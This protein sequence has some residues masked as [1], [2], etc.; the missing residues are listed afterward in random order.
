MLRCSDDPMTLVY[1]QSYPIYHDLISADGWIALENRDKWM[2]AITAECGHEVEIWGVS[3]HDR[4]VTY[5]WK[6]GVSVT[7]RL[8]KADHTPAKSKHHRSSGM[9]AHADKHPAEYYIIKGID[10]GA[11]VHLINKH[12]K[13]ANKPF[14]I[15]IG[16]KCTSPYLHLAHAIFYESDVQI[17]EITAPY[18]THTGRKRSSAHLIKLPKSVDTERFK[19]MPEVEKV[20]DLISAGRLIS[21]YKNYDDLF[22]LSHELRVA[23][24][25]GGPLLDENRTRWPQ[26]NWYGSVPNTEVAS[27][28]N[29]SRA[30]FY[31]SKRDYFPRAIVEAAACGLPVLCFDDHVGADVVPDHVGLR[32]AKTGFRE[33]VGSLF[34][35]YERLQQMGA[36]AR[37][38]ALQ[39]YGKESSR[40]AVETLLSLLK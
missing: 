7:I 14:A 28:L 24:I 3:D 40:G 37:L 5:P 6:E 27:Y 9:L 8:F 1:L 22:T 31:P 17:P 12:I 13:P 32:L 25:G 4:V 33:A 15:V 18:W 21:Y 26:V 34:E 23:F 29:T 16:G 2:P 19:P 38:H 39:N 30:F 11:G 10:G 20:N 36:N 35:D